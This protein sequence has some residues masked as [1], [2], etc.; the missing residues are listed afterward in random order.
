MKK[1]SET[2]LLAAIRAGRVWISDQPVGYGLEF[3]AHNGG[4]TF[5]IGEEFKAR[6]DSIRINLTAKGFPAGSAVLLISKG[7]ILSDE[8]IGAENYILA[9]EFTID[10]YSYFRV[11]VRNA[12]GK[13]LAFTNP[14]YLPVK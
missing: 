6:N 14:L 12:K 1:L 10:K 2:E 8:K 7:R 3:S 9:K 11:E 5:N 4:E 13:M